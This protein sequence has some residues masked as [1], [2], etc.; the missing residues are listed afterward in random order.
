MVL[1]FNIRF[2]TMSFWKKKHADLAVDRPETMVDVGDD[3]TL[4]GTIT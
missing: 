2:H 1:F 3:L 4:F